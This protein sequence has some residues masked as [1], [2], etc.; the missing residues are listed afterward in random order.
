MMF[1]GSDGNDIIE[2]NFIY[3]CTSLHIKGPLEPCARII[4]VD[5][6]ND[7]NKLQYIEA[8]EFYK[9]GYFTVNNAIDYRVMN[10]AR[11][12]INSN[13]KTFLKQSKRCDDWRLHLELKFPKNEEILMIEHVPILNLIMKSPKVIV[14]LKDLLNRE[15][16]GIFY[17]QIALR[18]PVAAK[19]RQEH[20]V[21][22]AEYHIDGQANNSGERFPDHW[23]VQVGIALN[24]LMTTDMGN[25]TV[26]PGFHKDRSWSN[27]CHEK[28]SKTLP[29]LGAYHKVCLKA[30]DVV[31]AHVLLPH[32]GGKNITDPGNYVD[33]FVKNLP[34]KTREMV[35]IRI[36]GVGINYRCPIRA[37]AVVDNPWHEFQDMLDRF[38][39]SSITID[40]ESSGRSD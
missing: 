29:D 19:Y 36:R 18:T 21:I 31:F 17:S 9:K 37:K 32:R 13:Y 12:Y 40:D 5:A 38:G 11:M 35:F 2:E 1:E 22:G 6:T 3:S 7:D 10:E 33:D 26:F 24:D 27:Y 34:P 16:D 4:D 28:R 15:L 20:Y 23:S 25:F 8:I 39:I 30:G 14:R